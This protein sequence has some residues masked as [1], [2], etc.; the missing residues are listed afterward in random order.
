[1][2]NEHYTDLCIWDDLEMIISHTKFK[3]RTPAWPLTYIWRI[4]FYIHTLKMGGSLSKAPRQYTHSDNV[5]AVRCPLSVFPGH[6]LLWH[7]EVSKVK[8]IGNCKKKKKGSGQPTIDE[9]QNFHI[10]WKLTGNHNGYFGC[11]ISLLDDS[12][13]E[14]P[15]DLTLVLL[16][17][18]TYSW[19]THSRSTFYNNDFQEI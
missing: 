1:M 19:L 18:L 6:T 10:V 14:A 8:P 7:Y 9:K 11:P 15:T 12:V 17:T 16:S 13:L 3:L 4:L 5:R 2:C